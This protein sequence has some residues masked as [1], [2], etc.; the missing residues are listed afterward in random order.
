MSWEIVLHIIEA[1]GVVI[2]I[3]V[4]RSALKKDARSEIV[5]AV[6]ADDAFRSALNKHAED[7]RI[8]AKSAI[9]DEFRAFLKDVD[10]RFDRMVAEAREIARSAAADKVQVL[11]HDIGRSFVPR[12]EID[13]KFQEV[14]H[15]LGRLEENVD[16]VPAATAQL[17]MLEIQ[18]NNL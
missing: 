6:L 2:S 8:A 18:R 1:L 7:A 10:A 12:P 3:A 11:M 17:V 16:K 14:N 5:V 13:A 9:A 15:R 4:A